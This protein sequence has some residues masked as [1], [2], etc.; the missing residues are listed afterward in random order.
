VR[1]QRRAYFRPFAPMGP[2]TATA[3]GNGVSRAKIANIVEVCN[4]SKEEAAR[5]LEACHHDAAMAIDRF[6][7]GVEA[8][9]SEVSAKKKKTAAA[10]A[11]VSPNSNNNDSG[12]AANGGGAGGG[13]GRGGAGAGGQGERPDRGERG[14]RGERPDRRDRGTGAAGGGEKGGESSDRRATSA[15]AAATG[16]HGSGSGRGDHHHRNDRSSSRPDHRVEP[17]GTDA[18]GADQHRAGDRGGDQ[19]AHGH[20]Q[21]QH[22]NGQTRGVPRQHQMLPAAPATVQQQQQTALPPARN[23]SSAAP[24]GPTTPAGPASLPLKQ[25]TET[26]ATGAETPPARPGFPTAPPVSQSSQPESWGTGTP[27]A[28][29][30]SWGTDA[31]GSDWA[32]RSTAPAARQPPAHDHTDP[33]SADAMS[34]V[35]PPLPGAASNMLSPSKGAPGPTASGTTVAGPG[36][37]QMKRTFNY[38]AA[39]KAGTSHARPAAPRPSL[40]T[41]AQTAPNPASSPPTAGPAAAVPG[42]TPSLGA[43]DGAQP[44]LTVAPA[45]GD[46]ADPKKRRNRGGRKHRA[47]M[48][49]M[50]AAQDGT[51][52][53]ANGTGSS[54]SGAVGGAADGAAEDDDCEPLAGSVAEASLELHVNPPNAWAARAAAKEKKEADEAASASASGTGSSVSANP[55]SLGVPSEAPMDKLSLQFG[56]FSLGNVDWSTN[57]Q[58]SAPK[59]MVSVAPVVAPPADLGVSAV[60]ASTASSVSNV[61]SQQPILA[62]SGSN[63]IVSSSATDIIPGTG[64]GLGPGGPLIGLGN[65]PPTMAQLGA[66]GGGFAPGAYGAP[67]PYGM[68]LGYSPGGIPGYEG[69]GDL[70]G[71]PPGMPFYDPA[72]LQAGLGSG[73]GKFGTMP[74][75]GLLASGTPGAGGKLPG[76]DMDKSGAPGTQ[77]GLPDMYMMGY[78]PQNVGYPPVYGFAPNLYTGAMPPGSVPP[79]GSNPYPYNSYPVQNGPL[80]GGK[81]ASSNQQ[82]SGRASFG[83]E[84]SGGAMAGGGGRNNTGLGDSV[85]MPMQNYLGGHM[86]D[87]MTGHVGI[88]AGGKGLGHDGSFMGGRSNVSNGLPQ[89]GGQLTGQVPNV[90]VSSQGMSYGNDYSMVNS[91]TGGGAGGP[92]SWSEQSRALGGAAGR[93][94]SA[95]AGGMPQV[96]S[97]SGMYTPAAPP[98]GYWPQQGGY[99]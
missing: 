82:Q 42:G 79:P 91:S 15:A 7:S 8:G 9:W 52:A 98:N 94:G 78:P 29:T 48:E 70:K 76:M 87:G 14:E 16:D 5:V 47:R 84:E 96:S 32:D 56:S 72:S 33:E 45:P 99:Y 64:L 86:A 26:W 12:T 37:T 66:G 80:G 74:D 44:P 35:K 6:L 27:A 63:T 61:A 20:G 62:P 31:P 89:S 36:V 13:G 21:T 53:A 23:G 83:F 17:R 77:G 1:G 10:A 46:G 4:V 40:D 49:A 67:S 24:N 25:A 75:M 22:A 39:A 68:M 65:T 88:G 28:V 81:F 11:L 71:M 95:N 38:A 59:S 41:S 50:R 19:N 92:G 3:A 54:T 51:G 93:D 30:E 58:P 43:V 55:V 73:P 97:A 69:S 34:N 57:D 18:R 85:Y 90:G 60:P 2:G